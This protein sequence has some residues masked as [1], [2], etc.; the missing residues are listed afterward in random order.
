[1]FKRFAILAAT[2]AAVAISLVGAQEAGAANSVHPAEGPSTQPTASA[3]PGSSA[4]G[5]A[6]DDMAGMDHGKT[7]PSDHQQTAS[8][9][10]EKTAPADQEQMDGMSEDEM[11]GMDHGDEASADPSQPPAEEEESHGGHTGTE[12]TPVARPLAAVVGAF[13]AVNGAVMVAAGLMRRRDKRLAGAS[14]H[15]SRSAR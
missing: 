12:A 1:M 13:A 14:P 4:S 5:T 9:D 6:H 11:A 15:L 2:L 7:A 8:A 10:H 3:T